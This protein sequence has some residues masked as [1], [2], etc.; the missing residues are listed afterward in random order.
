[1]VADPPH[2]IEHGRIALPE[3]KALLPRP[4]RAASS[5]VAS[6]QVCVQ[7][8]EMSAKLGCVTA[9]SG[10]QQQLVDPLHLVVAVKVEHDL[11]TARSL[12]D[13]DL[14]AESTLELALGVQEIGVGLRNAHGAC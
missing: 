3:V 10:P 14:R 5:P 4:S 11:A 6:R 2:G 1:M 9:S 8:T 12:S 13:L 7:Q